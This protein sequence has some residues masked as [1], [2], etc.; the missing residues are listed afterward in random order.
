M[1]NRINSVAVVGVREEAPIVLPS[2][3]LTDNHRLAAIAA[4]S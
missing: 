4:A 1:S 3:S 2:V